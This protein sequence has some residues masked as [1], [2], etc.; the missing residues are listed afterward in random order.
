VLRK[1]LKDIKLTH[2]YL[3]QVTVL[4]PGQSFLIEFRSVSLFRNHSNFDEQRR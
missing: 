1:N 3:L 2:K 4:G